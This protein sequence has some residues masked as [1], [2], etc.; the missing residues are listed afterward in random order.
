MRRVEV[1]HPQEAA[2][3][4]GRLVAD[5]RALL[6]P[7]RPG[8]QEPRLGPRRADHR[9]SLGAAVIRLRRRILDQV[10]AQRA[11]EEQLTI[12]LCVSPLQG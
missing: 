3:P 1:V 4:A 7:V 6:R 8:Q 12:C 5:G 11:D 2:H 9:P 10:K